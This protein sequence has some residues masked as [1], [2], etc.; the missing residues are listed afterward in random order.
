MK[1]AR[2][3]E[4]GWCRAVYRGVCP[5]GARCGRIHLGDARH[6]DE[7][8]GLAPSTKRTRRSKAGVRLRDSYG[9]AVKDTVNHT[10]TRAHGPYGHHG[11][12]HALYLDGGLLRT[13]RALLEAPHGLSWPPGVL[14]VPNCDTR[15]GGDFDKLQVHQKRVPFH[16]YPMT[17]TD[18]LRQ[19]L[20]VWRGEEEALEGSHFFWLV[21]WKKKHGTRRGPFSIVYLDYC[22]AGSR[23]EDVQLLL[24]GGLLT[25]GILGATCPA[26]GLWKEGASVKRTRPGACG[27]RV[28]LPG[29]SGAW[30][31]L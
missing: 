22:S 15:R 1:R 9:G 26:Y 24:E 27:D 8:E 29:R 7:G 30:W 13:T 19:C 5:W 20:R 21:E 31:C 25:H 17:S 10:L 6:G 2:E 23:R 28:L 14:H 12:S 16:L 18:F 3:E 4:A 11:A